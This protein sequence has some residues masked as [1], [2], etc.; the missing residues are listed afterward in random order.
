MP[1]KKKPH[2][3]KGKAYDK[4]KILQAMK[5]LFELGYTREK[6]CT[7]M[8][9]NRTTLDTW[10]LNDPSMRMMIDSWIETPTQIARQNVVTRMIEG[11]DNVSKWW[12]ERRDKESFSTRTE[13]DSTVRVEELDKVDELLDEIAESDTEDGKQNL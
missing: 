10:E 7:L 8:Q 1:T 4:E 5:P 12:L 9:F 6:V 3:Q 2:R 11:D 13:M